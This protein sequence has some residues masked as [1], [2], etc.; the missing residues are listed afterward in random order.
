MANRQAIRVDWGD[1]DYAA[2]IYN[3]ANLAIR[4]IDVHNA[5]YKGL[6]V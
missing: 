2:V 5:I 1:G 3:D 4:S 6:A